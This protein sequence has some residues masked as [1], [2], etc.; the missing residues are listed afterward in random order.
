V[1]ARAIS[2]LTTEG[3]K[4]AL[5]AQMPDGRGEPTGL[6]SGRQATVAEHERLPDSVT[7]AAGVGPGDIIADKYLID[8]VLGV[9]GMGVVF[10]ARHLQLNGQVAL[11][12]LS[13][14]FLAHPVAIGRFRREAQAAARLKSE[15]V[16]RVFDVGTHSNGLPYMVMEYLEGC[17]L[18]GLLDDYGRLTTDLATDL[19]IQTCSAVE[20]AHRQGIIHRDL[21]PSNLFCVPR[22]DGTLTIKVVDFGISKV[23]GASAGL[24]GDITVT[25]NIVGSPSYMSPEQM[26]SPN[27]IDHRTDLWSLGVVLYECVTGKLPFPASTY[28]EICLKVHQESPLPPRAHGV[29]LPPGLEAIINTC[30]AKDP[31]QRYA[32]AGDLAAALFALAPH[33]RRTSVRAVTPGDLASR[34]TSVRSRWGLP[35]AP[36]K[37]GRFTLTEAGWARAPASGRRRRLSWLLSASAFVGLGT[38]GWLLFRAPPAMDISPALPSA[39]GH[40]AS[41]QL[42]QQ[43]PAPPRTLGEAAPEIPAAPAPSA[44][45]LLE[46]L[47][48][49]TSPSA[50]RLNHPRALTSS[51]PS[52][53]NAPRTERAIATE[54]RLPSA[55]PPSRPATERDSKSAIW[56]R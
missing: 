35:G 48:P 38:V 46:P 5:Q 33:G 26:K 29:V 16:V 41:T 53:A 30:L 7:G 39:A 44:S 22:P 18:G 17:D 40:G 10:R 54:K 24:D 43:T 25:G 2:A 23:S 11:K 49:S 19:L 3:R 1:D 47:T 37:L 34:A 31:Q 55:T 6:G 4:V 12:F 13:A 50:S 28:A 32:T 14:Q 15:H 8:S 9:G 56:T 45:G 20:D 27:R 36:R 52:A 51:T 21:K 42:R